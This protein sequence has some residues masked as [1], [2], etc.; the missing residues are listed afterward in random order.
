MTLKVVCTRLCDACGKATRIQEYQLCADG[1]WPE[2]PEPT[3]SPW[4]VSVGSKH[5]DLCED[6]Y[7]PVAEIAETLRQ[8]RVGRGYD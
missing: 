6:C 3:R 5:Y 4:Y 1:Q 7:A 8:V 2:L